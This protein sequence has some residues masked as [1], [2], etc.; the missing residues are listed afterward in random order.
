MSFQLTFWDTPNATSSPGS[1]SGPAPS[2]KPASPTI[3]RYGLDP[4]LASLSARQAKERGLLT[5]GTSGPRSSTSS[6]SAAL[7]WSLANRLRAVTASAGST[8]YRLTWKEW[9]TPAGR[10]LLLLRGSAH[11]TSGSGFTGWPTP[12]ANTYGENLE[13][14]LARRARLKAQHGNGNGA[15][16]TT[17]MA[18]Q[19]SGWPT[20]RATDAEKNVRTLDGALSEI[21]RKG[22]PQDLSQASAITG[23]ARFTASGE[24][25]TGSDAGMASGGQ[26]NPAHPRWLMGL[27]PVWDD[28]ADM[29]TASLPRRRKRS[30][31]PS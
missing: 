27:P 5:S 15:G 18:A 9:A 14:E 16:M 1:G 3:S 7:S 22:S 10:S 4:A 21:A 13:N 20:T 6:A 17:A 26:L 25:L 2:G 23:P 29:A 19:L 8:L 30:S 28:C 31:K 24:M 11:R 12:A